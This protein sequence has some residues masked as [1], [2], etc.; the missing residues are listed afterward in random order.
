LL[1][2]HTP[3]NLPLTLPHRF[4]VAIDL[5]NK[6]EQK[7]FERIISTITTRHNPKTG[8]VSFSP[9]ELDQIKTLINVQ[10]E[11]LDIIMTCCSYIL[12][13]SAFYNLT[14]EKLKSQLISHE[15]NEEKS[16]IFSTIW[17]NIRQNFLSQLKEKT[18][19]APM[20]LDDI[21][22]T[23]KL[24]TSSQTLAKTKA[25]NCS[26]V[27]S[28]VDANDEGK[29]KNVELEFDSKQLLDFFDKLEII[30]NQLDAISK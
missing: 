27:L 6:I 5:Y 7:P 18:F 8:V 12:D 26:M 20:V 25:L 4:K 28:L 10:S 14:P 30:Q 1:F 23:L 13:Q 15:L 17:G 9:E 21:D 16:S 22:W 3:H 11:E 29:K 2:P 24:T 19:G